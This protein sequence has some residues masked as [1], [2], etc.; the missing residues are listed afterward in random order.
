GGHVRA[1]KQHQEPCTNHSRLSSS[2]RIARREWL[3]QLKMDKER[4]VQVPP[5]RPQSVFARASGSCSDLPASLRALYQ[6]ERRARWLPCDAAVGAHLARSAA[7][8][9]ARVRKST[10]FHGASVGSQR[11]AATSPSAGR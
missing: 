2:R 5:D 10:E 3:A 1:D 4:S 11:A 8:G 7:S 6:R 9:S